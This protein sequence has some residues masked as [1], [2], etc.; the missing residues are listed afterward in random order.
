MKIAKG[1][2]I[3]VQG[4]VKKGLKAGTNVLNILRQ[5]NQPRTIEDMDIK[6]LVGKDEDGI[7]QTSNIIRTSAQI[8][9]S[10]EGTQV[11][12]E[13]KKSPMVNKNVETVV[14]SL[15]T[16]MSPRMDNVHASLLKWEWSC[17]KGFQRTFVRSGLWCGATS[18]QEENLPIVPKL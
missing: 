10:S 6:L 8:P 11:T 14:N 12:S 17:N 13:S 4:E 3:E 2:W 15:K 7:Q 1:K 9:A 16:G 5:T 18:I